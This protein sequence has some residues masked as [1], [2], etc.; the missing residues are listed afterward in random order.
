MRIAEQALDFCFRAYAVANPRSA[1]ANTAHIFREYAQ[2]TMAV[3][4]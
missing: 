2:R 3:V 1:S 4:S